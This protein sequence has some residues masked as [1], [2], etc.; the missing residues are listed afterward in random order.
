MKLI[1]SH[2][3]LQFKN[4]DEDRE[5]I[6]R[7]CSEQ[8]VGMILVGCDYSSSKSVC[9]LADQYHSQGIWSAVGQHPTDTAL[10]FIK[11]DFHELIKNSSRVV[12]IGE[13][14]L[15]YYHLPKDDT[16]IALQE[17]Q[18][19]LF[20]EHLFLAHES[21][22]PLIIHCRDAHDDMIQTLT[23]HFA[24]G[25]KEP[26]LH[27][28][29]HGV[30]HCFTGTLPYAQSYL[31]LGFLISFTGIITFARQ[32]DEVVSAVP[33]EKILIETDSPFLTPVPFRGKKNSPV[34]VKYVAERIAKIKGISFEKV[35]QV[36][37]ENAKRLF[38]LLLP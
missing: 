30:M 4:Y 35:A 31:D 18:K 38:R 1:D 19:E 6:L 2:A 17:K 26:I 8:G 32:Y 25:G 13:C 7:Q 12:G 36:T 27:P 16:A 21:H 37:T 22:L 15:D 9:D 3:H 28:R 24:A 34:N 11:K 29:E 5:K 33:L 23:D 10:P 20:R 14:G